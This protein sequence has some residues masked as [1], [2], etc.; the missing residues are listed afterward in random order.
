MYCQNVICK[1]RFEVWG[2]LR[3]NEL[4]S[5]TILENIASHHFILKLQQFSS[6]HCHYLRVKRDYGIAR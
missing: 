6:C 5:F 4:Q 3:E 1:L 2:S